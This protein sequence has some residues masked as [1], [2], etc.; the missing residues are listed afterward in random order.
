MPYFGTNI[1]GFVLRIDNWSLGPFWQGR[2][3]MPTV[4]NLL[5]LYDSIIQSLKAY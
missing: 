2:S 1:I 5:I 4:N 3:E